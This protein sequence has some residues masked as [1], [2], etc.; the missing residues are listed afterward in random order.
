MDI[1]KVL[2][3][4]GTDKEVET[5]VYLEQLVNDG[6][7]SGFT[8]VH[9]VSEEFR[10]Q[11]CRVFDLPVYGVDRSDIDLFLANPLNG[12]GNLI[13]MTVISIFQK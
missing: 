11:L 7:P 2:D 4:C 13:H 3:S 12:G 1:Q 5:Y 9:Q 8:S 10:P 6:S